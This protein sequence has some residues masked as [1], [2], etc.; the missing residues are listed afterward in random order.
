V[1]G[2]HQSG[3]LSKQLATNL[4]HAAATAHICHPFSKE[5]FWLFTTYCHLNIFLKTE[6]PIKV[7]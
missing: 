7:D 6:K 3:R 4:S 1:A 2:L 5:Q